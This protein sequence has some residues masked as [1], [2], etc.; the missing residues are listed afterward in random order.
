MSEDTQF[1]SPSSLDLDKFTN[2]LLETAAEFLKISMTSYFTLLRMR[3]SIWGRK[4]RR[5]GKTKR[6]GKE[7]LLLH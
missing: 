6:I 7:R 1:Y 5:L 2:Y 4:G 3:T